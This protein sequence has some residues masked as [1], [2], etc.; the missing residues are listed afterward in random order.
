[1]YRYPSPLIRGRFVRRY[2]RFLTEVELENGEIVTAHN[3]NT[4]SLK[5]CLLPGAPVLL[6]Y[7]DNP[8]RKTRYTWE[9]IRIGSTWVGVNTSVPNKLVLNAIRQGLLDDF[10]D[11]DRVRAEVTYGD[12]R[13]DLLLENDRRSMWV[14]IKNVTYREGDYALFP[15]APTERGRKHLLTL[16]K[17]VEEGYEAAMVYIIGRTDTRIFAPAKHIDPEYADLLRKV[18]EKGIKILPY[19]VRYDEK[20]AQII[21]KMPWEW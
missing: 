13:L 2:K 9:S 4:G 3:T 20:G 19:E 15:D 6:Q 18:V 14:E 5:S 12:S 7:H 16:A 17:A 21:R 8:K 11:F 1:M 10:R